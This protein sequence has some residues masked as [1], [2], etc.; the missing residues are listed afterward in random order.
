ML[1]TSLPLFADWFYWK[2][3]Y[4]AVEEN[5]KQ[6]TGTFKDYIGD[7]QG[8]I[9]S[10]KETHRLEKE[11]WEKEKT[12]YERL[13]KEIQ[14]KY[15]LLESSFKEEKETWKTERNLLLQDKSSNEAYLKEIEKARLA[16]TNLKE[17]TL[18]F[19]KKC[20]DKYKTCKEKIKSLE[21]EL[22]ELRKLSGMQKEELEKLTNQFK[23]LEK[24]LKKEIEAKTIRLRKTMN[25]LY[26]NLDDRIS[27]A[28]G[29]VVLKN[30]VKP[31]LDKIITILAKYPNNLIFIEGHT[32]DIPMRTS[33]I[34][35]N[36]QLSTERALSVLR[37]ILKNNNLN[38]SKFSAAGYGE[39]RPIVPNTSPENRAS[40]RRVELVVTLP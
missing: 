15:T 19:K 40:N 37:Y 6:V 25:R 30:D 7:K 23:E 10:L 29:S 35:D 33:R 27:F 5:K 12:E 26:I 11:D 18:A 8:E 21:A 14:D 2:K 32:D 36:W 3:E 38:P 39:H 17:K 31:I 22:E 34:R 24:E 20:V 1:F 4:Q 28:P 13:L 16:Y 9:K